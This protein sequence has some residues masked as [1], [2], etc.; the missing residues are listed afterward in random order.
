L[1]SPERE[2]ERERENENRAM[3]RPSGCWIY[4]T[5]ENY[6]NIKWQYSKHP[7]E[8]EQEACISLDTQKSL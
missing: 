8:Q 4:N 1:I 3:G 6:K 5:K 2:R 7:E